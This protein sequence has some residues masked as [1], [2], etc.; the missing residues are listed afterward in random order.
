MQDPGGT[1]VTLS[2][3]GTTLDTTDGILSYWNG[4]FTT[5]LN[6]S[7]GHDMSPA[8][9]QALILRQGSITSTYSGTFD[10]TS[11]PEPFSMA[12]IGG[13]LIALAAIRRR[14]QV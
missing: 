11:V 13:G 5:Q 8:G 10:I 14:K 7:L 1:S 2:A 3:H 9:I 6:T 4:A 12:L